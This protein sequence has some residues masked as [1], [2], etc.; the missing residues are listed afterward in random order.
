VSSGAFISG[1]L[2]GRVLVGRFVGK[3]QGLVFGHNGPIPVAA[4]I[5]FPIFYRLSHP[6]YRLLPTVYFLGWAV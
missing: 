4:W 6:F 2:V 3:A 1:A 5:A